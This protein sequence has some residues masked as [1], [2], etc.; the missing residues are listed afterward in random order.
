[1][2]EKYRAAQNI[3]S[4]RRLQELKKQR[5]R[6]EGQARLRTSE[7]KERQAIQKAKEKIAETRSHSLQTV[8]GTPISTKPKQLTIGFGA[9]PP[10]KSRSKKLIIGGGF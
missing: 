2:Q 6:L 3:G 10:R 4:A 5:I 9:P 8:F 7:M 1:M